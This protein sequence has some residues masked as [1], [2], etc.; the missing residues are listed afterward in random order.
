MT[1]Q[2]HPLIADPSVYF[3]KLDE[4]ASR[5]YKAHQEG[6]LMNRR[7][8]S[9]ID[10][11]LR[12]R[13]G[14]LQEIANRI[15]RTKYREGVKSGRLRF[16]PINDEDW[17]FVD[18]LKSEM[19]DHEINLNQYGELSIK[20]RPKVVEPKE[21]VDIADRVAQGLHEQ[22]NLKREWEVAV[23]RWGIAKWSIGFDDATIDHPFV[24]A[25]FR[26]ES[27]DRWKRERARYEHSRWIKRNERRTADQERRDQYWED[28]RG[29][30]VLDYDALSKESDAEK[31]YV[32]LA[33]AVLQ[34]WK[35][36]GATL[37]G[38]RFA[39]GRLSPNSK[40]V[41]WFK[42]ATAGKDKKYVVRSAKRMVEYEHKWKRDFEDF[43][44]F[45]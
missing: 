28:V 38:V 35:A 5:L 18:Q 20:K 26:G 45:E 3:A 25:F 12:K 11:A 1:A 33:S 40:G 34:S 44:R 17:D 41:R 24:E 22:E 31:L 2:R 39:D 9:T 32:T 37:R 21:K 4:K 6:D 30:V 10:P 42:G 16:T 29:G 23:G 19:I 14:E 36:K 7:V 15:L 13:A 43:Q 27:P 8:P